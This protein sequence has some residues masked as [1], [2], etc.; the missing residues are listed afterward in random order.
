MD[1]WSTGHFQMLSLTVNARNEHAS[2]GGE[3]MK[4][5]KKLALLTA[6]GR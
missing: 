4:A 6:Q 1:E 5:L 2:T 3:D